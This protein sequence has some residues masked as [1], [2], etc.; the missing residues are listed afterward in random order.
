M[1][2]YRKKD[3]ATRTVTMTRRQ[4]LERDLKREV[5]FVN[6]RISNRRKVEIRIHIKKPLTNYLI[7]IDDFGQLQALIKEEVLIRVGDLYKISEEDV[8]GGVDC[9]IA[10]LLRRRR[11]ALSK[12]QPDI[13]GDFDKEVHFD[14]DEKVQE[15]IP[16]DEEPDD[17]FRD[18]HLMSKEQFSKL[19]KSK[20]TNWTLRPLEVRPIGA[21]AVEATNNQDEDDDC[22]SNSIQSGSSSGRGSEAPSEE[23]VYRSYVRQMFGPLMTP[24]TPMTSDF[25][26]SVNGETPPETPSPPASVPIQQ[27]PSP[28]LPP[29]F[30]DFFTKDNTI[31]RTLAATLPQDYF[32][33][34]FQPIDAE[35]NVGLVLRPLIEDFKNM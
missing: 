28:R 29:N 33:N 21:S 35:G 34:M 2:G 10:Y 15:A 17:E 12:G 13:Y 19:L 27:P 24:Q 32:F 9:F 30:A 7:D 20:S 14:W 26:F 8:L 16:V 18:R 5:T 25:E 23:D 22:S 6:V 4:R 1:A 3:K 11:T 31:V